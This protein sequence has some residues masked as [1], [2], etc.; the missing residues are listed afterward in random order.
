MIRTILCTFLMSSGWFAAMSQ[1]P[2]KTAA[3]PKDTV[4]LHSDTV[5]PARKGLL[6]PDTTYLIPGG[7]RVGLD[8][9]RF[10]TAIFQP[11]R[12]EINVVADA[13]INSRFYAAFEGGY[14]RSSYSDTSYSY[15]GNGV[16]ATI[17]V[18]Y[19]FLK[20]QFPQEKN[21]FYTGFRYGFSHLTYEVPE[22]TIRNPYWGG[23]IPGSYPKTSV[24]AHWVELLIGLK[25][26]VLKNLFLG[27]NIR[28]RMLLN[29]IK[30][31]E[32]TPLIIPGFGSGRKKAVFDVQYTVSY[33]IPLYQLKERV[34]PPVE[35][36]K[37]R[38]I[39]KQ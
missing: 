35:K 15:K 12:K 27:W 24:N 33:V 34:R 21:M 28:G 29:T 13:R 5:A 18:D 22:Y 20:R 4:P 32:F 38:K 19:N 6:P 23:K 9:S 30:N 26:E 1:A 17:G 31:D 39:P 2:V 36:K 37:D 16:F 25:A 3:P 11:Y 7:L 10:V 8:L 14:S